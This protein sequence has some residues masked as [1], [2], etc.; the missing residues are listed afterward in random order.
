MEGW[1][2]KAGNNYII[3]L[4]KLIA[5]QLEIKK[6]QRERV[7]DIYM[8]FPRSFSY[9]IEFILPDGYSAEGLDKLNASVMNETGGF[10]SKAKMEGNKGLYY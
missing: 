3:D 4:G 8:P 7:K 10:I 1:I 6:D 5:S 9:H 2:K